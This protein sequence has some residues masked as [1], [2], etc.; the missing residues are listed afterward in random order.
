MGGGGQRG[1]KVRKGSENLVKS[2]PRS[3]AWKPLCSQDCDGLDIWAMAP[4]EPSPFDKNLVLELEAP[5]KE[6][7]WI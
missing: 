7:V 3:R 6:P 1:S 4:T 5:G 2:D